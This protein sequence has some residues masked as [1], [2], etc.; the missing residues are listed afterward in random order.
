MVIKARIVF[1]ICLIN[2]VSA[3]V[4]G[5]LMMLFP[6]D[7]PLGLGLVLPAMGN[8][9]FQ[10]FFQT[11]FWSGLALFLWNG[12]MNLAAAAAFIRK[13][14]VAAKLSL[15]AGV[16]MVLWCAY[17]SLFL[18]NPAAIFYAAV[19]IVQAVLSWQLM[20]RKDKGKV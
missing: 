3:I 1:W 19:G 5:G 7:T 20:S 4:F 12:S 15:I 8:F 13:A 10:M 11:L 2:G 14:K 16:M 6:V 18:P 9:P 17:E